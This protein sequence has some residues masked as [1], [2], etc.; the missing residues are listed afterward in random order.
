MFYLFIDE[1]TQ[2]GESDLAEGEIVVIIFPFS[3]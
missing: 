2:S 1:E 3:I